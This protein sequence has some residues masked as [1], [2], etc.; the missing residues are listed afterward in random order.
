MKKHKLCLAK[1]T[2]RSLGA[3]RME[4]IVGGLNGS[5]TTPEASCPATWI[6]VLTQDPNEGCYRG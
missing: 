1:E 2:I 6:K 3:M 5:P 4:K